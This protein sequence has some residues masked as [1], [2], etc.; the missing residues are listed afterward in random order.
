MTQRAQYLVLAVSFS[1][2]VWLVLFLSVWRAFH[3]DPGLLWFP[4]VHVA[5]GFWLAITTWTDRHRA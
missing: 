2:A 3:G 1:L 5:V 4:F